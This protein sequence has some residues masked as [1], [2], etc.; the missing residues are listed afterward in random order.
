MAW[1]KAGCLKGPK[2]DPGPQGPQGPAGNPDMEPLTADEVKAI[3]GSGGGSAAGGF[4]PKL[5]W[6]FHGDI[7][8]AE[9]IVVPEIGGYSAFMVEVMDPNFNTVMIPSFASY[10][11]DAQSLEK[12]SL[13]SIRGSARAPMPY[14]GVD[15]R[16]AENRFVFMCEVVDGSRLVPL[17]DHFTVSSMI[18]VKDVSTGE[19]LA[20]PTGTVAIYGLW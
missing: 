14:S 7:A 8:D 2:G 20:T 11:L 9:E 10:E 16:K 13:V 15:G 1:E 19:Y 4:E 5:L 12:G 6:R 18:E 17:N 3:V